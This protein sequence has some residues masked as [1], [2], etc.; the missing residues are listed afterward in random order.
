MQTSKV[1]FISDYFFDKHTDDDFFRD[2]FFY[3]KL[4]ALF[5]C[6]TPPEIKTLYLKHSLHSKKFQ[7]TLLNFIGRGPYVSHNDFTSTARELLEEYTSQPYPLQ[8]AYRRFLSLIIMSLDKEIIREYFNLFIKSERIN[9]RKKAYEV[10]DILWSDVEE[11]IW[12][13]F[14]EFGDIG[15]LETV[16]KNATPH[17]IVT[18][19]KRIWKKNFPDNRL[20]KLII[21]KTSE[22]ELGYFDFLKTFEP[23]FYIHVLLARNQ[24]IDRR[25][26]S[27]IVKEM[28][29]TQN[30]FLFYYLGLAQEWDLLMDCLKTIKTERRE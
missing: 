6:L 28:K 15:A 29:K 3:L 19:I 13:T 30:G 10:A 17:D 21:Q 12:D 23:T 9:D 24:K 2:Q 27:S 20:K 26:L 5:N 8:I 11:I 1:I 14:F 4:H 25:F 18:E 22:E 16:I 7:S